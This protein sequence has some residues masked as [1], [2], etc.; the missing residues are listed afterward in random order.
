MVVNHN[1]P[2]EAKTYVHRVGRSARAGRFGSAIT[3]LTQYDIGLIREV[4]KLIGKKLQK[5]NVSHKKVTAYVTDVL[6]LKR[7]AEIKLEREKF[8]EKKQINKR[9]DMLMSG[10][11]PEEVEKAMRA[12]KDRKRKKEKQTNGPSKKKLKS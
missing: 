2:R 12:A 9:K 11:S 5:L 6:M 1:V 7:E 8:G 4:E 3:F 10:L